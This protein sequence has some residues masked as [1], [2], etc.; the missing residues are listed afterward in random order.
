MA[1]LALVTTEKIVLDDVGP[2]VA[3]LVVCGILIA[4]ARAFTLAR[5]ERGGY[6]GQLALFFFIAL[7]GLAV[8]IAMPLE[9][10][11]ASQ[12]YSLVGI[13]LSAAIA[14]SS[15]TFL[16]NLIAGGMLRTIRHFEPGDW[17][18][19]GTHFGRVTERGLL[20]TE[21]QTADRDLLTLPNTLLATEPVQVVRRSGTIV[22]ASVGL[23]YDVPHAKAEEA[24][25]LAAEDVAL[26]DAFVAV[27][28]LGDHTVTYRVAGK[29]SDVDRLISTRS[30]LR[31][32]ILDRLHGAGIEIMSP[33]YVNVARRDV[34][35]QAI[36]EEI[37]GG[38]VAAKAPEAVAF[39]K[40]NAVLE[41][42]TKRGALAEMTTKLEELDGRLAELEG[43]ERQRLEW[44]RARISGESRLLEEEI[45]TLEKQ[46]PEA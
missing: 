8:L 5:P 33:A 21:I 18:R 34:E 40:A 37:G 24:L 14:L 38:R 31:R 15:T 28:A 11:L 20:H 36:P 26:E 1:P 19:V 10:E 17:I 7:C 13:V 22:D 46:I 27:D 32:K 29:L 12:I 6:R 4:V 25:L 39:D 42:E 41:I 3:T 2:F 30:G 9:K 16:G 44:E 43:E 23:G 45:A 35:D